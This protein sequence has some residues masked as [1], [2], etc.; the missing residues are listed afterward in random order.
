MIHIFQK[1]P[2]IKIEEIIGKSDGKT[3]FGGDQVRDK[4][5]FNLEMQRRW[6]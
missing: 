4:N 2:L 1:I 6:R 5:G 3:S